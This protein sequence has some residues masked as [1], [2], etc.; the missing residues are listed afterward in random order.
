MRYIKH[1]LILVLVLKSS[2]G[3]S[4]TTESENQEITRILFVF[5]GS[6]SMFGRWQSGQKIEVAQR[7]MAKMLDSLQSLESKNFQIALRV[8]GHQKPVPP[9]DCNDTKLEVPFGDNNIPR[10]KR[11]IKGIRP[12]G[13]TPIARS[14]LRSANDFT[15]CDNCRNIIIL[16]TDGVEACDEDP[17][18]ASRYLQTRG[19]ALKP[20]IIGIGLDPNFKNT[21]ECVGTFFDANDEKTFK[22]VLGIVISQALNNTTAQI[23]LLDANKNPTETNIPLTLYNRTSGLVNK[24][25]VHTLNTYGNPDTIFLDP[26]VT[27]DIT[28]HSL[29]EVHLDSVRIAASA[30]NTIGIDVP[31]GALFL[32]I[33]DKG[34]IKYSNLGAVV[35]K[36]GE[37]EIVHIQNFNETQKYLKGN[38]SLEILTLP[39]LHQDIKIL[40]SETTTLNIPPPGVLNINST[41]KGHGSILMLRNGKWEWLIDL[42]SDTKRQA[43]TMQPGNYKVVFRTSISQNT[44]YS[45]TK[46]FTIT[47][48][49]STIVK[50]N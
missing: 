23:S 3:F 12:K 20:F 19:I 17:C 6:K 7:L 21:F 42:N 31:R 24:H 32:K 38:Y 15:P 49:T 44:E 40:A 14:L 13:T 39:R 10:I 18:A 41:L 2:I 46:K 37:N 4:Q 28:V 11:V 36:K 27:Y 9:Q 26:L 5:D 50:L 33:S 25:I 16:I 29:P 47:S 8:Y 48:G 45:I 35:R 43:I 30:H 1:I 34:R 22:K